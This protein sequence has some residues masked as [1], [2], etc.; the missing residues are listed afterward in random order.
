MMMMM[1]MMTNSQVRCTEANPPFQSLMTKANNIQ[2]QLAGLQ[3]FKVA[4]MVGVP[5][6]KQEEC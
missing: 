1:M 6:C 3:Q 5:A 4:I 2:L